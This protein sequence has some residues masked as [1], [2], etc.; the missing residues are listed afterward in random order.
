M[1]KLR[2]DNENKCRIQRVILGIPFE[3]SKAPIHCLIPVLLFMLPAPIFYFFHWGWGLGSFIIPLVGSLITWSVYDLDH[4]D[5]DYKRYD[6]GNT[7]YKSVKKLYD[8]IV[9][10]LVDTDDFEQE[11]FEEIKKC[12]RLIETNHIIQ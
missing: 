2:R 6:E 10:P 4:K 7:D 9:T 3:N 8:N 1:Y 11:Q 12:E 5:R